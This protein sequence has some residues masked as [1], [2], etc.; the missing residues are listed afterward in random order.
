MS[1]NALL[2]FVMGAG[3]LALSM[4]MR[5]RWGWGHCP[6]ANLLADVLHMYAGGPDDGY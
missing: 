1:L 3:L 6:N 2:L 4:L 5:L